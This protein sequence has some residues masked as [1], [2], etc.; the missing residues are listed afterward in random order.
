MRSWRIW[1]SRGRRN[2]FLD[3]DLERGVLA[4]V[5][6]MGLVLFAIGIGTVAELMSTASLP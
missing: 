6:L 3:N 5:I 1:Q 4:V 2:R